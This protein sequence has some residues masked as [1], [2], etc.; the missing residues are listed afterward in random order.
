MVSIRRLLNIIMFLYLDI[1]NYF[2]ILLLISFI[3]LFKEW[4][5]NMGQFF[6]NNLM[7]FDILRPI[8]HMQDH[9]KIINNQISYFQ[10]YPFIS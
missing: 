7:N 1:L 2:I 10:C 9:P 6:R 4:L 5:Q 8:I 3:L